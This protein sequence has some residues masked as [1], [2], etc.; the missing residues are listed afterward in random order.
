MLLNAVDLMKTELRFA[1]AEFLKPQLKGIKIRLDSETW[2]T[3]TI[4]MNK[5]G[6][7]ISVV[8]VL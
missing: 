6:H 5:H 8:G 1:S 3:Q 7:S 4:E 2:R